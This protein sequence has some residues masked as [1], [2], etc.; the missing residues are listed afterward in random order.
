MAGLR[1]ATMD[2]CWLLSRGYAS[3]SS[4]KL[5]GDRY[6]L[7]DRQRMAVARCACSDA[8]RE[9]RQAKRCSMGELANC[10]LWIDGYNLLITLEMAIGG[11]VVLHAVDGTFRDM[12]S[13]HGTY[14]KVTETLPALRLAGA[15]L[16]EQGVT[17]CRWL[18]DRPV[19]NSGR[20]RSLML[21][22]AEG[23]GWNWSVELA[24]N[25][26]RIL[27]S[28]PGPIATAD[29]IVLDACA[30]WV[31]LAREITESRVP[32]AWL[33]NL[34]ESP[35]STVESGGRAPTKDG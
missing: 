33:V 9:T 24:D 3:P 32:G 28:A 10:E 1:S 6:Q 20:L 13:L 27:A 16:E 35:D 31:N 17:L 29:S 14:R 22:E 26:D 23:F 5:V 25:P 34:V 15:F 8:Q 19:S 30:S 18:L 12:A 4:L 11:G 7:V 21:G 2:L